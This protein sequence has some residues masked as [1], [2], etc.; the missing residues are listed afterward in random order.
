MKKTPKTNAMRALDAYHIA[1]DVFTYPEEIHAAEGVAELLGVPAAHVFKTLVALADGSRP[2]LII[3]PGDRELN[4]RLVARGV[5]AKTAHMAPQREAERLTG[6][7]VGGISPLALLHQPGKHF[8]VYLD[9]PG[10]ALDSLYINGGQRGVNL[11][12]R[13]AD[14]LAIT[15]AKVIIATSDPASQRND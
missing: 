7:K 12:L 4:L 5:G 2:L 1:Y 10:A 11:H 6:L 15:G 14:L 9:A 3:T 13:V 8:E